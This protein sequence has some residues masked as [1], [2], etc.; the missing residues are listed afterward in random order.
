M[1]LANASVGKKIYEG[2]KEAAILRHHPAP[3]S[4]QF[5]KLVKAAKIKVRSFFK[6]K[7][8]VVVIRTIHLGI[9]Y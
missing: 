4:G 5:E 1:I 8:N 3:S 2:Y 9:L 6:K 7:R